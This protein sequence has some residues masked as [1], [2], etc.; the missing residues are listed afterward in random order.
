MFNVLLKAKRLCQFSKILQ[1]KGLYYQSR[2]MVL[3]RINSFICV[4]KIISENC[5][6]FTFGIN[7]SIVCKRDINRVL[8]HKNRKSKS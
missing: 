8:L 4:L 2:N 5:S 1:W 6:L 7:Q 3:C